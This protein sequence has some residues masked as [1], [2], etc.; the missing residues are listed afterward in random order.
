MSRRTLAQTR[1]VLLDSGLRLLER[2]GMSVGVSHV[3]LGE[4]AKQAGLTTGA[5]YRCWDSQEH[6]H[7]D[8][9]IA[10]LGWRNRQSI[11]DT[12]DA[13]RHLVDQRAAWQEVVRVGAARYLQTC[14]DDPS[15]IASIA[16][17]STASEDLALQAAARDRLA[18]AVAAFA[19]L[20]QA[21]FLV[22]DRAI[23]P[24]LTLQQFS[25]TLAALSEGYA[26]QVLS[27]YEHPFIERE[28][29]DPSIGREWTMFG[30]M[31]EITVLAFT[32]P[33]AQRAGYIVQ[34]L[35]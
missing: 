21:M 26:L 28:F 29:D 19:E 12:V 34:T 2:S 1:T 5:A 24:P 9:A 32:I 35:T 4:V 17:R 27:G 23:R 20:Y 11:A 30:Y 33:A 6:F 25:E 16:L 22:Y 8:L 15:F 3:K 13:I 10:A 7:R 31:V 14:R 18:S